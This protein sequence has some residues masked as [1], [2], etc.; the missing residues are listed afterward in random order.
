MK[1]RR[2]GHCT[3]L[4]GMLIAVAVAAAPDRIELDTLADAGH[5][6]RPPVFFAH[7]LHTAALT[8]GGKGQGTSQVRLAGPLIADQ[9]HV[10][11]TV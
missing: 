9:E 8:A 4:A 6:Q 3:G 1:L 10:L 5:R 7:D 11:M 2:M